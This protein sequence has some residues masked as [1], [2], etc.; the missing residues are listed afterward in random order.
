MLLV[1]GD[2]EANEDTSWRFM[3]TLFFEQI[4]SNKIHGY[5]GDGTS[6]LFA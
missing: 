5:M 3:A 4:H 2:L 1:A 6:T